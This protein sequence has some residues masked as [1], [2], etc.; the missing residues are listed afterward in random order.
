MVG[1]WHHRIQTKI[2]LARVVGRRAGSSQKQ[3]RS[4]VYSGA[5]RMNVV[6][7]VTIVAGARASGTSS[8]GQD[9]ETKLLPPRVSW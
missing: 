1:C 7:V 9:G 8:G 2:L 5:T 4:A 6:L 3:V